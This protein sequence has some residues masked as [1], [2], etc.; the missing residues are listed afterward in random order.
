MSGTS[1][2]WLALALGMSLGGMG[3]AATTPAGDA[4]QDP[5]LWLEDIHGAKP[6]AWVK[7]QNARTVARFASDETFAKTRD[8]ILEVLDSDAH[9]PYVNRMGGFLYNFWRD[10]AHPRG[11]WR[12]TT[13]EE[14][15]KTSPAWEVLLDIDALNKAEGKRWV[16]KGAQCLKP[17][18]KRCLL[19]LSPDGGEA[20]REPRRPRR[21]QW[22][23]R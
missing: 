11:L 18:Y 14:F 8:R 15:R 10:K 17:A 12:R 22:P 16:F 2:R 7:E 23:V 1:S 5:Y 19:S 9:I 3:H 13:L 20:P 4:R 21:P 6:M